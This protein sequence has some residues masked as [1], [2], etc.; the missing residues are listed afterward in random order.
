MTSQN[1]FSPLRS[2]SRSLHGF[3]YWAAPATRSGVNFTMSGHRHDFDNGEG[4]NDVRTVRTLYALVACGGGSYDNSKQ[5]NSVAGWYRQL[6]LL[7][8]FIRRESRRVAAKRAWEA[9]TSL[10]PCC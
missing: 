4:W 5:N 1:E 8:V 10:L 7:P 3:V 6:Q 2:S 9:F